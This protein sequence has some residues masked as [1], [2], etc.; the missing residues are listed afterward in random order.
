MYRFIVIALLCVLFANITFAQNT[1][2]FLRLDPSPRAASLA[3]SYVANSDDPNVIFYNP[4]GISSL[5]GRPI[6]FSYF[7]HL[8][9]INSASLAYSQEFEGIGRFGAGIQYINYGSFK[10]T[11]PTGVEI[12]EFNASEIA[13]L[14]GYSGAIST[15]LV[16]GANVKFI[17]SGIQ[18]YSSTGIAIDVGLQ[19][20]WLDQG[21]KVGLSVKNAGAQLSNFV[22]TKEDLPLDVSLGV[23]KKLAHMPFEFFFA[24]DKLNDDVENFSDRFSNIKAGGEFRLSKV[25]NLRFGYDNEKRKEL[26]V[27]STA[28]LAGF[29]LGLGINTRGYNIDYAFSSLGSIGAFHRIGISTQI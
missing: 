3:G 23:S 13:F 14:V 2:E 28:G 20:L 17:Y 7:K 10:E 1:Y 12:G 6:S 16:Y 22:D 26:K 21:W 19:Y 4:A 5:E 15:Q 25:I 11:T 9:D 18:D 8:L 27:G 24:F 29:N